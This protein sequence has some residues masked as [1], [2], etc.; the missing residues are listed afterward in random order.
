[1]CVGVGWVDEDEVDCQPYRREETRSDAQAR[2]DL[3][4]REQMQ[5]CDTSHFSSIL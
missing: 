5:L 3:Q 2:S 1:M 4:L